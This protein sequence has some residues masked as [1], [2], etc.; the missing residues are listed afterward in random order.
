MNGRFHC[1]LRRPVADTLV[2]LEHLDG[3][4][5]TELAAHLRV[6]GTR[7][8]GALAAL[9]RRGLAYCDDAGRWWVPSP[10]IDG[11]MT[12]ARYMRFPSPITMGA[13][14]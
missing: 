3:P 5:H 1:T 4:T 7:L 9:V 8:R 12:F 6:S 13:S 11:P 14:C 10:T 2:A